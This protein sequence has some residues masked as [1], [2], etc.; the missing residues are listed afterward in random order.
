MPVVSLPYDFRKGDA[1][2]SANIY[3]MFQTFQDFF[4]GSNNSGQNPTSSKLD[5]LNFKRGGM[6]QREIASGAVNAASMVADRSIP[7]TAIAKKNI[8]DG[9]I[10]NSTIS[11]DQLIFTP[12]FIQAWQ[13]TVP[14]ASSYT[15]FN[16]SL[17]FYT[18]FGVFIG[19]GAND[20]H[21]C[22]GGY[23]LYGLG[24]HIWTDYYK[25]ND[26]L[27]GTVAGGFVFN[28]LQIY[29]EGSTAIGLVF[30][31]SDTAELYPT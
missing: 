3:K 28:E 8:G 10:A 13:W 25:Y 27:G 11:P 29:S 6:T 31:I 19:T 23:Y 17:P 5:Y 21:C 18:G 30:G 16:S 20:I 1:F 4:N 7:T 15:V 26:R 12:G 2:S 24:A 9:Q 14:G 22:A